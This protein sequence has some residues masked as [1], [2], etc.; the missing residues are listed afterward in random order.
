MAMQ[1]GFFKKFYIS[2]IKQKPTTDKKGKEDFRGFGSDYSNL[3]DNIIYIASPPLNRLVALKGFVESYKMNLTKEIEKKQEKDKIGYPIIEYVSDL[4]FNLTLNLPAHS[5]NEAVNNLAKIEELQRLISILPD[6]NKTYPNFKSRNNYFCVWFK[7][8]IFSGEKFSSY[9]TPTSITIEEIVKHGF[10]C[11]IDECNYEPDFE[12]G[13]FDFDGGFLYPKNIKLSLVLKYTGMTRAI[14][15]TPLFAFTPNGHFNNSDNGGF[16]FGLTVL[17]GKPNDIAEIIT[18]TID[19]TVDEMNELE[20]RFTNTSKSFLFVSMD[21]KSNDGEQNLTTGKRKRW[22]LFKGFF[23]SFKRN[24]AVSV[25]I[26]DQDKSQLLGKPVNMD[27]STSDPLLSYDLKINV[28]SASL[29]E[30]KKNCAKIQ[31]L[32]RFFVRKYSGQSSTIAVKPTIKVYSPSLIENP[33]TSGLTNSFEGMFNN[34][35]DLFIEN[36]DFEVDMEAGFFEE[37]GKL[38][39]KTMSIGLKLLENTGNL[40]KN[41]TLVEENYSLTT[42]GYAFG[43]KEHLFPFPKQTS[44]LKF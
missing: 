4:S 22:V 40:I 18:E 3:T 25:P 9:P 5:T 39:P 42:N 13:F 19:Y 33:A 11:Y 44:K 8:L 1:P 15:K 43:S 34:S 36:I 28:P 2:E 35:L 31:Y 7:N 38:Y 14:T 17:A 20:D 12:A 24:Y 23:E 37:S 27:Q 21:I 10:T 29:N 6:V 16:P 41:Y 30:A 26:N 32:L